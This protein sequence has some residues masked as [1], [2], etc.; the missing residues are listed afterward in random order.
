MLVQIGLAFFIAAG[1]DPVVVW[2]TRR[3]LPR[4]AAVTTVLFAGLALVGAFVAAAIPPLAA[5]TSA[6]INDLPHWRRK[7]RLWDLP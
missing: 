4:W 7:E 2:L 5:Q 3:G 1:L 6:L